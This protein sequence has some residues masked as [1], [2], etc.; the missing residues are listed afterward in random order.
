LPSG[1][2]A[3]SFGLA[4][5]SDGT[6]ATS[7]YSLTR[8]HPAGS[9]ASVFGL[10]IY[11]FLGLVVLLAGI[12]GIAALIRRLRNRGDRPRSGEA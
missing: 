4:L 7:R 11:A 12:V 10:V 6:M 9:Q 3:L 8:G 1:A 5:R 2:S